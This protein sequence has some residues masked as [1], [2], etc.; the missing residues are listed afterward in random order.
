[1]IP[2][3]AKMIVKGHSFSGNLPFEVE[4]D[5]CVSSSAGVGAGVSAVGATGAVAGVGAIGS[6]TGDSKSPE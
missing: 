2:C 4:L 5:A 6:V 3:D 1:M